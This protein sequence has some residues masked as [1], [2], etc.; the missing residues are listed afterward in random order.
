ME[1]LKILGPAARFDIHCPAL[2]KPRKGL[3]G[4][5][6]SVARGGGI[7]PIFKVLL[8]NECISD[9][10]YC[11]NR[12]DSPIRRATFTPE[13]LARTFDQLYRRGL[14]RGIFL[15]SALGTD[16]RKTMERMIEAVEII[17]KKYGFK[18]YVH[19]K[20]LPGA[21]KDLVERAM[22]LADR[23][24]INLEAPSADRLSRLSR[25]KRLYDHILRAMDWIKELSS[26]IP[27][28]SG[29]TTQFVVGAAGE[30]DR[31]L[32]LT[33]ETLL[34]EYGL[35]RAYFS[36][37]TPMPFTP[38]EEAEPESPLREMRL[39][40]AE[41]L[42]RE[43]GFSASQ[44]PFDEKGMLPRNLDPKM[45]FAKSHPELYPVEL[46]TASYE[47]LLRVPGIGPATAKRLLALR[48]TEG[49]HSE[50]DLRRAGVSLRRASPFVTLHGKRIGPAKAR[51]QIPLP[52]KE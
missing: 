22:Q 40:Q 4:V 39:Y 43:Y 37:F 6:P 52:L 24:S 8:T 34:R 47:E 36:A 31:E 27:L 32:L 25:H 12:A 1:K 42:L 38:L 17:R 45:A 28:R 10:A 48:A 20:I 9:C 30:S 46:S 16:P 50:G 14:V 23:V 29:H 5:Y 11:P 35:R 21:T 3:G 44:L 15:S 51:A 7:V 41:F 19:L 13:E 2:K 26:K 49:L 18:G 33:V